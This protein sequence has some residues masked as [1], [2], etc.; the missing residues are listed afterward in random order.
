[1]KY[2]HK[3]FKIL[4]ETL[5][6]RDVRI[7]DTVLDADGK[8]TRVLNKKET[9]LAG[10]KQQLIKDTFTDWIW[11]DPER[12]ENLTRLYNERFNKYASSRIRR[13]PH[14]VLRHQPGN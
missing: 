6:L 5:N 3:R 13:K 2:T 14:H 4:E 11:R 7:F 1:M 8:E 12:R 10:Q 9:V